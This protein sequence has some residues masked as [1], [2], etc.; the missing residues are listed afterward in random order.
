M[1][2]YELIGSPSY[3]SPL[4]RR[5]GKLERAA[6]FGLSYDNE[7]SFECNQSF[8]R[9]L[10][11]P[12]KL[13]HQNDLTT[14]DL[15]QMKGLGLSSVSFLKQNLIKNHNNSVIIKKN[16][17]NNTTLNCR[18]ASYLT[19]G[20]N[21]SHHISVA[22]FDKS[23]AF[24]NQFANTNAMILGHNV[25]QANETLNSP[26][27]AVSNPNK[28]LVVINGRTT[29]ILT[30]NNISCELFG[31][32]ETKLIGM[33]LKDLLDLS[34][35]SSDE[36]NKQELLM[37]SN[38]LDEHGRI[39]LCSGK[40]F[41]AFTVDSQTTHKTMKKNNE[42]CDENKSVIP[43]SIYM[44]KLTDESEPK[45]LCVMEPVQ[46]VTGTFAINV[47]GRVKY[48][49]S[50]F[51]YIF[52]YTNPAD[53]QNENATSNLSSLSA[54]TSS[55]ILIGKEIN[56]LIPSMKIPMGAILPEISK[57]TL[58][59]RSLAGENIP[60]KVS[61]LNKQLFN[62]EIVY[63]CA[64]SVYTNI[65]GLF[66]VN[67]VT[68]QIN[69]YNSTF[70]RLVFGFDEKELIDKPITHLIPNF[71]EAEPSST[72]GLTDTGGRMNKTKTPL[73]S[74]N[75][76]LN[77]PN[78][79]NKNS[80]NKSFSINKKSK[81]N[82][83]NGSFLEAKSSTQPLN[84]APTL[85]VSEFE[86]NK[87]L[88]KEKVKKRFVEKVCSCCGSKMG[89][90]ETGQVVFNLFEE[91]D[92]KTIDYSPNKK[93]EKFIEK[94]SFCLNNSPKS[95]PDSMYIC[96]NVHSSAKKS[97]LAKA[98]SNNAL[99][100]E[101]AN[102]LS[103]EDL[104]ILS[105]ESSLSPCSS[106]T[107]LTDSPT[108]VNNQKISKT[109][110]LSHVNVSELA[111]EEDDLPSKTILCD[112]CWMKDKKNGTKHNADASDVS[113]IA[114]DNDD[115]PKVTQKNKRKVRLSVENE[116]M[117]GIESDE[118]RRSSII[119]ETNSEKNKKF[120]NQVTSTPAAQLLSGN[121]S[122]TARKSN[123]FAPNFNNN[124]G[125]FFGN[126]LHND[127]AIIRIFYQRKQIRLEETEA[128]EDQMHTDSD[129]E[130]FIKNKQLNS[131]IC[132][133]ISRDPY[134]DKSMLDYSLDQSQMFKTK[135]L[136]QTLNETNS[137]LNEYEDITTLGR[138]ASGFVQ[139]AKRKVD[140]F[141]VVTKYILKS[142][143]YK[144][145]WINDE[146]Y[147]YGKIP[148]ECSI[149]CKL[150][151]A[152][153]IKVLEVFQDEEHVQMVM[154]KHGCGMD[155]F[156][157]I[158]RQRNHIEESLASHIFRQIV[159]AVAY[160][161]T[162]SLVHRDIKDE[163]IVINEQF[164]IKL[165][166]FGS[167]AYI[168]KGKKFATFCGTLDYCSP[169]VLLGNK[170]YGPELD[171]W[172]CGIALYTLIFSENPF[173]DAEE[174]IE[175]ILKP[176]FR[177]SKELMKLLFSILCPKPELRA[178]MEEIQACEWVNQPVDINQFKW[179]EVV[180]CETF[181]GNNAGDTNREEILQKMN[182]SNLN[183]AN[184]EKSFEKPENVVQNEDAIVISKN[185]KDISIKN[186]IYDRK[187]AILS[188]SF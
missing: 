57:Q 86:L 188:K 45:C 154:E 153:I 121:K 29:E 145:N 177:V 164:Q 7:E 87:T 69:S 104:S 95:M 30:A 90:Q 115:E 176:P 163:N 150:D 18:D 169:D 52:G 158:D 118:R 15:N 74:N 58:T 134:S 162:N 28:A 85:V 8:P 170:Y 111:N 79:T 92:L 2:R 96:N 80:T 178:S 81:T 93:C 33:K 135:K 175:C 24:Y 77:I 142:K 25:H 184:L 76:Y 187:L 70:S 156:E 161:H 106:I 116:S 46:R 146:R 119:S 40:I 99:T 171:I 125:L 14:L 139:L 88:E 97:L 23:W 38:R 94:N 130:N 27:C 54:L 13:K 155:L 60:I 41:D 49:N 114:T 50:N 107:S 55:K 144:E 42:S 61:L 72:G 17:L 182:S 147:A 26:I 31:Y 112:D 126:G 65:S 9:A 100:N 51:S 117:N 35:Q 131:L 133:W 185:T 160:L 109:K 53:N 6:Q 84:K 173:V 113:L 141:E 138:G 127:G 159:S 179:E 66:T 67:P 168:T 22:A 20:H 157:F 32:S 108:S 152:N 16:C 174:T 98:I 136:N 102:N 166:D 110:S 48:Y 63:N 123:T 59:G 183:K 4:D 1:K 148:L 34:E 101:K 165:I 181:S 37:E 129:Q 186:N 56:E 82:N 68:Y 78:S 132:V 83:H 91:F 44:L 143:I 172:T 10:Q 105:S 62:E 180:R 39:V 3:P 47:K 64:V 73:C 36:N 11:M 167:A 71:F 103:M 137:Y 89:G 120:K 21:A 19:S 149:L 124:D 128:P 5:T 12:S 151:H 75:S 140:R 43:I 122:N